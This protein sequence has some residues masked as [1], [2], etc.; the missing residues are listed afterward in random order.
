[1]DSLFNLTITIAK[2]VIYQNRG[3]RNIYSMR[4]FETL[5]EIERESEEIYAINNDTL[6]LY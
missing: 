1:M 2:K 4:Q 3:K 6:E 5:L